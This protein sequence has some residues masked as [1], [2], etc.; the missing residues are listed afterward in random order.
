MNSYSM[1]LFH[2]SIQQLWNTSLEQERLIDEISQKDISVNWIRRVAENYVATAN[3]EN[4]KG[5]G[6]KP[7]GFGICGNVSYNETGKYPFI[8][9][10]LSENSNYDSGY[11]YKIE[12]SLDGSVTYFAN[13]GIE[14]GAEGLFVEIRDYFLDQRLLPEAPLSI[15]DIRNSVDENGRIEGI[16]KVHISDIIDRNL[17]EFLDFISVALTGSDLLM[18]IY[19]ETVALSNTEKD[20]LYVRVSGDAS[21]ILEMA[22]DE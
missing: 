3:P 18:N 19:Y 21:S 5:N 8:K 22:G 9:L 13:C 2:V 6:E 17:D 1:N 14:Y 11:A 7:K 20:T 15:E 12:I 16:I 10:G 4:W